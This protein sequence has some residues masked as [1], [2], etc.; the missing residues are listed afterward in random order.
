MARRGVIERGG[1]RS[2]HI[3]HVI[4][5][6]LVEFAGGHARFD[7][8]GNIIEHLGSESSRNAHFFDIGVVL[9]GNGHGYKGL[10]AS[11]LP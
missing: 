9:D 7:E 5:A 6:K 2:L 8:W 10:I 11:V 4:M 1:D 3:H